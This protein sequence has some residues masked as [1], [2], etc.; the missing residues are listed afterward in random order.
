MA[1]SKRRLDHRFPRHTFA[2]VEI[3]NEPIRSFEVLNGRVPWVQLDC[4]DRYKAKKAIETIDPQTGAFA[5]LALS[6]VQLVNG[7]RDVL[8]QRSLV[9]EGLSMHMPHQLERP[10]A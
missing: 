3:D 9:V 7:H 5:A 1:D 4:S 6:Q 8:R 2:G 10:M